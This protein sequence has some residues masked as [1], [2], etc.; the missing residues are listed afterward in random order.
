MLRTR[1]SHAVAR[2]NVETLDSLARDTA[3]MFER[4]LVPK[5]ELLAVQVALADARQNEL[6]AANA[7]EV[8]LA[9]YNRWLGLPLDRPVELSDTLAVPIEPDAGP[10]GADGAG[11]DAT[12]GTRG[13][14]MRRPRPT[15]SSRAPSARGCCRR[16][17]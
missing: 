7:A 13:R 4:E 2:S 8:A 3:S 1:K 10:A 14:S 9:A 17:R 6:R 12:D 5:N 11:P 16:S 15:A